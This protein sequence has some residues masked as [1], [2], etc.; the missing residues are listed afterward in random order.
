[1]FIALPSEKRV[2][3]NECTVAADNVG[4]V[5][6]MEIPSTNINGNHSDHGVGFV[7]NIRAP[8]KTRAPNKSGPPTRSFR[9]PIRVMWRPIAKEVAATITGA[10]TE[11]KPASRTLYFHTSQT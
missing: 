4:N 11:Y 6:P 9:N 3:G 1:M 2:G 8:I 5:S 10:R 7:P